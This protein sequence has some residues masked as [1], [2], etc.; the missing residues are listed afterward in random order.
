MNS[1]NFLTKRAGKQNWTKINFNALILVI[2]IH[3]NFLFVGVHSL[4]KL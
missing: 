4:T 1:S 3:V 2:L